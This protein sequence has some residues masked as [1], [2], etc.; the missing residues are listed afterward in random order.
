MMWRT[1]WKKLDTIVTI[2]W[3]PSSAASTIP[4][5]NARITLL[6]TTLNNVGV[7]AVI[8]GIVVPMVRG[9][10]NGLESIVTW[11]LVGIQFIA[12]AQVALGRLR[13]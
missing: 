11:M 5:H 4:V 9:E 6:A 2:L 1:A 3:M 8:A 13:I 10:I 12:A 7:G